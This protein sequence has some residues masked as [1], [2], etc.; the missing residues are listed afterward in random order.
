MGKRHR[1]LGGRLS[2]S[3]G[4]PLEGQYQREIQTYL[5]LNIN[6]LSQLKDSD[7]SDFSHQDGVIHVLQLQQDPP[8]FWEL[9]TVKSVQLPQDISHDASSH[10]PNSTRSGSRYQE[11]AD[12]GDDLSEVEE[13]QE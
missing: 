4:S 13:I 8:S 10:D 12:N 1:P 11:W 2:A 6:N 3:L 5:S 7:S 9:D